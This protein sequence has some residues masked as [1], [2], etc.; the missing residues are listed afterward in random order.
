MRVSRLCDI[1]L[2]S[3]STVLQNRKVNVLLVGCGGGMFQT[4]KSH[5]TMHVSNSKQ[6]MEG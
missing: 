5:T 2:L 6:W 4:V 1:S 3:S